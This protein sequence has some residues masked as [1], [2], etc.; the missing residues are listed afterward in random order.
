VIPHLLITDDDRAFRETIRLGFADRGVRTTLA[1]NGAEALE[2][3]L[4]T[5]VHLLLFDQHMPRLTGLELVRE[6]RM[7]ELD[8]PCILVSAALNE[9]IVAEAQ[10]QTVFS[11]LA[12]PISLRD[13]KATV[14][15]ALSAHYQWSPSLRN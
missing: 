10:Q 14:W 4:E 1:A 15:D 8:L 2:I 9:E 13:V 6:V 3:L 11:I 12:K 5:E 7:R